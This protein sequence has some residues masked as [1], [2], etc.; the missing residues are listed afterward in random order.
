[1]GIIFKNFI[2]SLAILCCPQSINLLFVVLEVKLRLAA[3]TIKS[4]ALH[5]KYFA[6]RL[7]QST[8][9]GDYKP[10][11]TSTINLLSE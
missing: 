11:L 9:L 5:L 8:I 7:R 2:E 6:E 4:K 10:Q 3:N 1:L